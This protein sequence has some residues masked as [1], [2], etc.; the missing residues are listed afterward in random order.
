MNQKA[1]RIHITAAWIA[2]VLGLIIGATGLAL[3]NPWFPAAESADTLIARIGAWALCL[4]SAWLLFTHTLALLLRGL[5]SLGVSTERWSRW[6]PRASAVAAGLIL[7]A[8]ATSHAAPTPDTTV[9]TT[10][11]TTHAS[12]TPFSAAFPID[13]QEQQAPSTKQQQETFTIKKSDPVPLPR[14]MGTPARN[15]TVV[16]T[17]GDTLWDIA[18]R[19]LGPGATPQQ[20]AA[21]TN[22]WHQAN[23]DLLGD[24]P[25]LIMPGQELH[26][27]A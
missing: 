5:S 7:A 13:D 12:P 26:I 21:E 8:P 3:L 22:R 25:H 19:H 20:I 15:D 27:P 1:S 10:E 4:I 2:P 17:S 9:V 16:V 11:T 23:R 18:A 24:N 14:N 6:V